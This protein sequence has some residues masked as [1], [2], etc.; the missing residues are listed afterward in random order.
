MEDMDYCL[1]PPT[2]KDHTNNQLTSE[3][4]SSRTFIENRQRIYLTPELPCSLL[5]CSVLLLVSVLPHAMQAIT[6]LMLPAGNMGRRQCAHTMLV[7]NSLNHKVALAAVFIFGLFMIGYEI[8]H[9]RSYGRIKRSI[10]IN[11]MTRVM[12]TGPVTAPSTTLSEK[13]IEKQLELYERYSLDMNAINKFQQ[14]AQEPS[15]N[16][17]T[18]YNI[19][20]LTP[21]S[22]SVERLTIFLNL[23]SNLSYPLDKVSIAFGQDSGF[24]TTRAAHDVVMKYREVFNGITF[25]EL[26]QNRNPISHTERHIIKIQR[27]RRMHMAVSRN[28]LLFKAIRDEHDWVLWMDVDLVYIPNNLIQLVLSPNQPIVAPNCVYHAPFLTYDRNNWQ[29]TPKSLRYIAQQKINY[30]DDFLMIEEHTDTASRRKRL[31]TIKDEGTVVPLD[32]IGGCALLINATCHRQGLI[33]PT[34]VFDSHVETEGLAKMATKMG[35]PLYGLPYVQVF[36]DMKN[37]YIKL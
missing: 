32:G 12:V 35:I 7:I 21:F 36:H 23:L 8:G 31:A 3:Y 1:G 2:Y 20:I 37:M 11:N 14:R 25:Y 5:P 19:L 24:N 29:E 26:T 30:G 4:W 22:D 16:N 18:D 9:Y 27:P 13:Q 34:F 33:F 15:K 17:R 6:K 28:E 10:F